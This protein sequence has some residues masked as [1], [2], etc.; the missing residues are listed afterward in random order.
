MRVAIMGSGSV[1]G[2]YGARLAKAGVDVH[3]IS[4]GPHLEAMRRDGL[5]IESPLIEDFHLPNIQ[6]T[7]DPQTIGQADLVFMSV[8]AFDL[9]KAVQ[10]IE[11]I[12]G[13]G[14][15]VLPLLN[16][17]DIPARIGAR[18]GA[19]R[20]L[21]GTVFVSASIAAPGLIRHHADDS[22]HFG[23]SSADKSPRCE[24]IQDIFKRAGLKPGWTPDMTKIV[25]EKFLGVNTFA[26]VCCLLR[27]P[28]GP[29]RSD[30]VTRD[31]LRSCLVETWE[32]GNAMRVGLEDSAIKA[33][34]DWTDCLP[35]DGKPSMLRE[36][37]NGNSPE[38]DNNL[39]ER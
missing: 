6:C 13:N 26:G 37:E 4:R 20:V 27:Q 7:D 9:D 38:L 33:V 10:A 36:L 22:I 2:F 11:P 35:L 30:P 15:I 3:F 19:E 31:L 1:G 8:K 16:G 29:V 5:R 17:I 14:G 32:V 28:L 18:I 34:L 12:L 23:E 24:A 21:T 25:W 39:K